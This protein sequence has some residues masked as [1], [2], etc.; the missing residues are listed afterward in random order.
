MPPER[1]V[2]HFKHNE[3][4]IKMTISGLSP[5]MRHMSWP[6]LVV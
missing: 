1:S 5:S 3:E 4:V 6:D 2:V